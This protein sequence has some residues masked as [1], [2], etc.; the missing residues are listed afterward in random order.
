[1]Q[2]FQ[3][4]APDRQTACD[5]SILVILL[6]TASLQLIPTTAAMLRLQAGSAEPMAILPAVWVS[7]ALSLTAGIIAA[8]A[9]ACLSPLSARPH[10]GT[11]ARRGCRR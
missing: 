6:N 4:S 9:M 8:K 7:T 1:M 3:K 11:C 2:E 5:E 10:P